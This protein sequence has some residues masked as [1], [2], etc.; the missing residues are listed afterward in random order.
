VS[1]RAQI[2]DCPKLAARRIEERCDP[3][4]PSGRCLQTHDPLAIQQETEEGFRA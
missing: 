4:S 1:M 2:G 3:Y